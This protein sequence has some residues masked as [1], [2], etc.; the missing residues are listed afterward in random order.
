[1]SQRKLA[2]TSG[3]KNS[4]ISR[5]EADSVSPDPSTLEKL[6]NALEVDKTLLYTKCGYIPEEFEV[7]ARKTGELTKEQKAKV[8][9]FFN[10]TID[11]F[12]ESIGAE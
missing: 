11:D 9:D 5:L 3:L 4:T 12:L 8:Y 10:E 1:M 6:A 2:E 7:I